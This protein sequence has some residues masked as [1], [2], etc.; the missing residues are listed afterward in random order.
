MKKLRKEV[1][2]NKITEIFFYISFTANTASNL[3]L[4]YIFQ[5]FVDSIVDLDC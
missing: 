4:I 1:C 3:Y 5:I 2:N